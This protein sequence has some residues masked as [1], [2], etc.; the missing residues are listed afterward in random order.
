VQMLA[1]KRLCFI[2]LHMARCL[3]RFNKQ[4]VSKTQPPLREMKMIGKKIVSH[5]RAR[6]ES[7]RGLKFCYTIDDRV[8]AP[9]AQLDRAFASE[10]KGQQFESAR[11][12]HIPKELEEISKFSWVA[13]V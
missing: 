8:Y 6:S 9:V 10:A 12:H 13:L 11:A 4:H 2:F 7:T 5:C 1:G 3:K